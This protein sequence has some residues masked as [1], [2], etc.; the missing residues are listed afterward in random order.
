MSQS[1]GSGGTKWPDESAGVIAGTVN[2]LYGG[3]RMAR[4]TQEAI[5]A[6][7]ML[8]GGNSTLWAKSRTFTPQMRL[9]IK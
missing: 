4:W 2:M 9:A 3:I 8:G 5:L 1:L 6:T 7:T